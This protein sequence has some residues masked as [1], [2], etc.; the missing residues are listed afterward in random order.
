MLRWLWM[1]CLWMVYLRRSLINLLSLYNDLTFLLNRQLNFFSLLLILNLMS[2]F[3]DLIWI[4]SI[5]I[6]SWRLT[7]ILSTWLLIRVPRIRWVTLFIKWPIW[8]EIK[9]NF[10]V[11]TFV[12]LSI[13]FLLLWRSILLIIFI[14][15]PLFQKL[16]LRVL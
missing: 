9:N 14:L 1:V 16:C 15:Y 6:S 11:V 12:I 3:I 7:I 10:G 13:Y 5:F 4:F 8:K 2:G